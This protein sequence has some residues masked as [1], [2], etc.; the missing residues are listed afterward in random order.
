MLNADKTQVMWVGTR[1]QALVPVRSACMIVQLWYTIIFPPIL[2]RISHCSSDVV[3]WR[4][5][6]KTLSRNTL[7]SFYTGWAKLNDTTFHF[8]LVTVE[9]NNEIQ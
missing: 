7:C 2:Q 8:L 5:G 4:E 6:R 9:C 3:Y 1:Q